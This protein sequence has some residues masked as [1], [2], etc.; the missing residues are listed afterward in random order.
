MD[1]F[2]PTGPNIGESSVPSI[3]ILSEKP[4]TQLPRSERSSADRDS[5]VGRFLENG[6]CLGQKGLGAFAE[7]R[8]RYGSQQFSVSLVEEFVGYQLVSNPFEARV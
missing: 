4:S 7:V 5:G 8:A 6:D 2:R 3:P 1:I